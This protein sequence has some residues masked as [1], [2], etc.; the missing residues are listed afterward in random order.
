M[1]LEVEDGTGKDNAE[2]YADVAALDTYLANLGLTPATG[3]D[4]VPAKEIALRSGASYQDGQYGRRYVGSRKTRDQALDW[5]RSNACDVNGFSLADDAIPR[6]VSDGNLEAARLIVVD[7]IELSPNVEAGG[8][9][10]ESET[11]KVGSITISETK[12]SGGDPE[13]VFR[14][15]MDVLR[16]VLRPGGGM[17]IRA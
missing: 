17:T 14:T 10:V 16:P 15:L 2:A 5:P 11:V 1:A 12:S 7:E 3:Q 9:N 8:S 4:T 6:E 13:P